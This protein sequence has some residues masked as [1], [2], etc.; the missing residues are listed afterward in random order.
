M[1]LAYPKPFYASINSA[2]LSAVTALT[3]YS[4]GTQTV[5]TLGALDIIVV[6]EIELA[7]ASGTVLLGIY[8]SINA[9]PQTNDQASLLALH[10]STATVQ[11]CFEKG[12]ECRPGIGLVAK[13]ATSGQC[14]GLITG[15]IKQ[16]A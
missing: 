4:Q 15:Y 3:L 2:D 12:Y 7:C 10:R 13:A 9:A 8:N 11:R 1:T 6:E 5:I 14:D 16:Q